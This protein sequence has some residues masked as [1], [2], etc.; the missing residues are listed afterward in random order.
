MAY[1]SIILISLCFGLVLCYSQYSFESHKYCDDLSPVYG[2]ISLDQISGVW[3][4]VEKIPHTRGEYKIEHTQEC[5]YIDIREI[6][7]EVCSLYLFN[8]HYFKSLYICCSRWDGY[9]SIPPAADI[10]E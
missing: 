3:Y 2:N 10:N 4:G 6:N 1:T 7:I 9:V 5:F 8:K